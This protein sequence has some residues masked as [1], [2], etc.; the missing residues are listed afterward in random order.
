M[1]G[2]SSG[3]K[4]LVVNLGS[5]FLLLLRIII[6]AFIHPFGIRVRHPSSSRI[7]R[8]LLPSSTST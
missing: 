5:L 3:G 8:G 7:A 1:K 2:G 4:R 6:D